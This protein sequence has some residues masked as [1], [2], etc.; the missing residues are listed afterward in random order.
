MRD[1]DG[2][3]D[4]LIIGANWKEIGVIG[5]Y[6]RRTAAA[7][8]DRQDRATFTGVDVGS[9]PMGLA[10]VIRRTATNNLPTAEN[11]WVGTNRGGYSNPAWDDLERRV[12][13]A[14]EERTRLELERE[15]L[16]LYTTEY[17][18]MPLF[19]RNDLIPVGGGLVGPV[20]NTGVA[21]RGFILHTWNVHE[22]TIK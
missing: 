3:S 2:E 9:N 13:G 11:R 12:L 7:L 14:L 16:R 4:S 21:H 19:F 20:A 6:E 5:S 22:W 18:M 10:A 17:P 1:T 8:R 15:L